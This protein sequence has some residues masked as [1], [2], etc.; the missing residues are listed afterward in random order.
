[1][2]WGYDPFHYTTPEGSYATDPQGTTRILEYR[3]MV[4][5]LNET[6]LGVVV[7]V[8]YNH[9]ASAGQAE[10]SVL[11]QVVP[12]YYQRLLEDGSLA[13]STC[14]AN[15]ATEHTMMEKLMIDSIVT[16]ATEYKVDGFRF[17]LMGHHSKENLLNVRAAL[18][19][20]TVEAD[21]V[22]GSKIYVYG[23]G[24]NFGEVA[25]DARFVQATQANMAGTGI[26][27]FNDRLRDAVRGGGPFDENPRVQGLG[28]GLLSD[29]N[30]DPVNGDEAAQRERLL[31]GMDQIK[32]G[33]AGN[34]ADFS[35]V[36]RTGGTVTGKDVDY[37]GSPTGYTADP[38]ENIL[39]VSAHDNETLFDSLALKLP[40][41]SAMADRVRMQQLSLSTV[42]LGQGVSF[43]HAGTDMLRSKS[44]DRNSYDSGDWFNTLDF[45]YESNNFGVGL[46]PAP[47]NESKW[48]Y[49]TPLLE[50]A[51][52][53][54]SQAD[55]EASVERFRDLLAVAD[56][57]PLFSLTTAEQVQQKLSY[58]DGSE[59]P[60]LIVM[61]LDDT[62]GQ[63]VD[64]ALDRVVTVF[65]ATDTEQVWTAEQLTDAGL[66]LSPVQAGGAD[67]VVKGATF[68]GGTF[69]VPARTTA[70]FVEPSALAVDVVARGVVNPKSRGV[71]SFTV[72]SADGF[73]PVTAVVEDSLR[74]GV[75]GEEDSIVG[76][77]AGRDANGDGMLDLVCRAR[78]PL[79]GVA[80]G[81]TELLLTGT[82][83]S[84]A[85]LEGTVAIRTVPAPQPTPKP[86]GRS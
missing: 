74:F 18:D 80:S 3:E 33:M 16:W 26:G 65:N 73:D 36:D 30:G 8:V 27:T 54:P 7:D 32:V 82:T 61:H 24:W 10:T 72:L 29:P 48:P 79:T 85:E 40:Q 20:L 63:S 43:F 60:G 76:C 4:Q 22:D 56:S 13:T 46:P 11:D 12:G 81:E 19:A 21:G 83:T 52:I 58:V 66:A 15:T 41:G 14:C 67:P 25:N 69:T 2:N 55:I 42:A 9:T 49:M 47:D 71:L 23:E 28:S 34:L 75:T 59:V 53:A 39:Y 68:S 1:F 38:Q 44:L 5:A 31:L 37:N 84:G 78:I 17:D 6:D 62:V 51:S 35:F 64:P 45:S 70:V 57:S 77:R 86:K 50:D